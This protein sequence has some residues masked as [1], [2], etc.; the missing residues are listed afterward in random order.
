MSA[1]CEKGGAEAVM[2]SKE[3]HQIIEYPKIAIALF[4]HLLH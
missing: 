4:V 2:S 1:V 3:E